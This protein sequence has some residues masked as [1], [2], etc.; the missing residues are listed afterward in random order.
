M[1]TRCPH[2][3]RTFVAA[4]AVASLSFGMT[5]CGRSATDADCE[6]IIDRNVEAQMKA[7]NVGD[8]AAIAKRQAELKAQMKSELK[9]CV[10]RR[11]TDRM[12]SCVKT[13][14]TP[15][16]IDSCLR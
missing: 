4:I 16:A 1:S 13:A 8:P 11:V 3:R 9:D 14:E 10:G 7:M 2:S 6:L 12:M 15:E 5:G